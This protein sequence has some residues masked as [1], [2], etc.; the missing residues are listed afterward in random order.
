MVDPGLLRTH[1][2][3]QVVLTASK[4]RVTT[5]RQLTAFG[6]KSSLLKNKLAQNLAPSLW[7]KSCQGNSPWHE[8]L[9]FQ[10]RD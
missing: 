10:E 9:R 2:L 5:A 1:P 8:K 7:L 3:P 4:S 6:H